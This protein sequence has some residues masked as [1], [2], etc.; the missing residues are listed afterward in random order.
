VWGVGQ[1]FAARLTAERI[2]TAAGLVSTD[3]WTIPDRYGVVLVRTQTELNGVGRAELQDAKPERQQIV[4]SRSFGSE[5][6]TSDDLAQAVATFAQ[7]AAEKLR[8]RLLSAHGVWVLFHT[9]PFG[10]APLY[11]PSR[12][13]RLVAPTSDARM[14][15][16]AVQAATA[17]MYRPG[18]AW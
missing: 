11:H 7:R 10:N 14:T 13:V 12:T 17:A 5:I 16:E 1:K 18:V 3:P 15:M 2:H 6:H 8:A 9:N 4:V